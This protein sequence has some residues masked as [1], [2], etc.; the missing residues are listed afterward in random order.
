M[1]PI[2]NT[3]NRMLESEN[4]ET[5]WVSISLIIYLV[6]ILK[7]SEIINM[8]KEI[9][10]FKNKIESQLLKWKH[11]IL[12]NKNRNHHTY[13][14]MCIYICI[15]FNNLKFKTI[16]KVGMFK[17]IMSFIIVKRVWHVKIF[18]FQKIY[19]KYYSGIFGRSC[20]KY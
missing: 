11:Q 19:L 3:Y 13:T 8:F 20:W 12:Y 14:F 10:I 9:S 6:I 1:F 2:F 17:I 18:N 5:V 15:I 4:H 7:L 16:S